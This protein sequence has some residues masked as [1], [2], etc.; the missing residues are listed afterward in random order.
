M[1][2][3]PCFVGIDVSKAQ[4]DVA[5]RPM[6]DRWECTNDEPG[7]T[8]LVAQL[9]VMQP[10]LIVLEATGG[11]HRAV[12]AALVAAALPIVVVNPRQVRDFAKAT[13]QLAKT[14]ILDAR[15]VAHFAEAIRPA[16]RPL[17]DAQTEEL[18]ALLARRRQLIAMRTAEQNRLEN[19]PPRLRTD[20]EAHIAWL[21]QRVATLD[22]DL[23]TTLRASP[24]WRE[25]ETLY[26]S[27]PGL[28][29]VCARTL[30]LD[31]PEL[32]TLSRQRIAALVGV[33]PFNRDSGTLRGTRTTWGGRAHVR[34]T[35]YM[36]TLVAVRYNPVLKAFYQRLCAAGKAKKVA[37][38]ACMRKLLTILNAMGKHQTPWQAQE[39]PSA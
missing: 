33:A 5:L 34:A 12:V 8:A 15:A 4:L 36:S 17:P 28:G 21:E 26:R 30:V 31:L 38:T 23:D 22:D 25:R 18:R 35:L 32:G 6:G 10:T 1:S 9:Q 3:P 7:I 11:Y 24:V 2:A 14:D 19:A 37:L 27:V 39:V 16:P 29:P 13:G 20:I